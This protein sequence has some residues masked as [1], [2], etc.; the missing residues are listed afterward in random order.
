[1]GPF[2]RCPISNH[3]CVQKKPSQATFLLFLNLFDAVG[4]SCPA[5]LIKTTNAVTKGTLC[6]WN[7][8]GIEID[9][10]P[11]GVEIHHRSTCC[12]YTTGLINQT[13]SEQRSQRLLA[14]PGC[15]ADSY[16]V[17]SV[18]LIASRHTPPFWR[19]GTSLSISSSEHQGRTPWIQ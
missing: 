6:T 14:G 19:W 16:K 17:G 5:W 1:M 9:I 8:A 11:N 12:V 10:G 15:L 4:L 3:L 2:S 7:L 13:N 18:F